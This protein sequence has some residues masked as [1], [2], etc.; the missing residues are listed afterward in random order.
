MAYLNTQTGTIY[1]LGTVIL[2]SGAG[3]RLRARHIAL[4]GGVLLATA[5][6][7]VIYVSGNRGLYFMRDVMVIPFVYGIFLLSTSG[8]KRAVVKARH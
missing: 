4:L 1:F 2:L 6:S 8:I 3:W 5:I 7:V